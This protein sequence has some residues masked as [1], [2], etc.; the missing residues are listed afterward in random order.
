LHEEEEA[1]D[2]AGEDVQIISESEPEEDLECPSFEDLVKKIQKDRKL[3][4]SIIRKP[5]RLDSL[6]S[7]GVWLEGGF[8]ST[9]LAAG[10]V[11]TQPHAKS[12]LVTD[13]FWESPL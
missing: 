13:G 7:R 2:A 4:K 11:H 12:G 8:G 5:G 9:C 3:S 6:K 10:I 1:E